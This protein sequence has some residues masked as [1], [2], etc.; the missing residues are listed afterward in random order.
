MASHGAVAARATSVA[1]ATAA[2]AAVLVLFEIYV[3]P[4]LLSPLRHIPTPAR[5]Q[6]WWSPLGALPAVLRAAPGELQLLWAKRYGGLVRV[7]GPL[8]WPVV[9]ATSPTALRAIFGTHA[10]VFVRPRMAVVM[11]K[12]F[13]GEGLLA[14]SGAQHRRQRALISPSFRVASI[15]ALTPVIV[16]ST[17]EFNDRSIDFDIYKEASKVTIDIIGRAGFGY[18]FEAIKNLHNPLYESYQTI[19]R[20]NARN[21]WTILRALFPILRFVPTKAQRE[22][23]RAKKELREW[24]AEIIEKRLV[25]DNRAA[26][27]DLLESLLRA[28]EESEEKISREEI[29][30]QVLT[31]L[32]AGHETTSVSLTWTLHLLSQHP[33]IQSTLL[34]ELDAHLPHTAT[35]VTYD[36]LRALP[37]LDAV[38]KESLRLF[39]PV[40]YVTRQAAEDTTLDGYR[41]PRGTVVATPPIVLHRLPAFWGEDA[42]EFVPQ[43][44]MKGGG[45]GGG[46]G[47]AATAATETGVDSAVGGEDGC[48]TKVFGAYMPFLLGP[49]SCIGA[50]F[51]TTELK[52]LLALLVREFVFEPVPGFAFKTKV[53]VT[54]KP[55][56][57]LLLRVRR[58][59][60]P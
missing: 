52:V 20:H 14:A 9:M 41:I 3:R 56:P 38:I 29:E 37:Y 30:G 60:R 46:L 31:F 8:N 13:V 10:H 47:K 23:N 35:R 40:P 55:D 18:D 17:L 45:G 27:T 15:A 26:S 2:A 32:L 16:S 11:L 7:H 54:L 50:R 24:V 44:W 58:R 48:Q 21:L 25:D 5:A 6:P 57:T 1:G 53:E 22:Y 39:P 51:A 34:A 36:T 59:H 33:S 49:R 4:F 43:R 28:N 19:L 12:E 42:E